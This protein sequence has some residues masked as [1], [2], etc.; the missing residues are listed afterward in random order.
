MV[1][2]T[3]T[4]TVKGVNVATLSEEE[5][6]AFIEKVKEENEKRKQEIAGEEEALDQ[7]KSRLQKEMSTFDAE[8]L[9]LMQQQQPYREELSEMKSKSEP[10]L[11][12]K[13]EWEEKLLDAKHKHET[14]TADIRKWEAIDKQ[15]SAEDEQNRDRRRV[16]EE[17]KRTAEATAT[18][19]EGRLQ[20]TKL[21]EA[22]SKWE[23]TAERDSLSTLRSYENDLKR[24]ELELTLDAEEF[25]ERKAQYARRHRV[26]EE[27]D[28]QCKKAEDELRS[29]GDARGPYNETLMRRREEMVERLKALQDRHDT[30]EGNC[31][32]YERRL[33]QLQIESHHQEKRLQLLRR[34]YDH[35]LRTKGLS[36]TEFM[37]RHARM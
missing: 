9:I 17:N 2:S 4:V 1:S 14:V 10:I 13:R 20:E 15:L 18:S 26:Y 28:A 11:A 6:A 34:Q 23:L 12:L 24:V 25:E 35:Y 31:D 7:E 32:T 29:D 22:K 27:H 3:P 5:R 8:E 36:E 16:L 37:S 30:H 19:I 21:K 33:Q